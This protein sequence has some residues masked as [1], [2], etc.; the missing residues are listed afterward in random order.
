MVN[1]IVVGMCTLRMMSGTI[2][3]LA[4]LWML[5]V[6]VVE[7]ALLINSGL[8]VVGPVVLL[9]TT[10]I[11]LI[12]MADHMSVGKWIWMLLGISCLCIGVLKK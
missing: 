10:T 4:A 5:R 6:N 11:G 8:A 2:E 9:S 7:K 12:G 3:I 1:K